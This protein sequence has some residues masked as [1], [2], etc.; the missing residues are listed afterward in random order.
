MFFLEKLTKNVLIITGTSARKRF[1]IKKNKDFESDN[2][3]LNTIRDIPNNASNNIFFN[4]L[5]RPSSILKS[6][7]DSKII[8]SNYLPKTRKQRNSK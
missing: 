7:I 3:R 8:K 2:K 4:C 6:T 5:E 1:Q